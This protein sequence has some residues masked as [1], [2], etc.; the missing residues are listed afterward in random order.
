M[1]ENIALYGYDQGANNVLDIVQKSLE[2][3]GA[4][5][6]RLGGLNMDINDEIRERSREAAAVV[7]GISSSRAGTN[8]TPEVNLAV[9]ILK[10]S[11][12]L[13]GRILFIQD[14]PGSS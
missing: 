4:D 1:G 8:G 12:H 7:L 5:V 14:F 3:K 10:N 2:A 11:P 6:I 9:D 13:S